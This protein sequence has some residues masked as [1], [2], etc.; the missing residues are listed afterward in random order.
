MGLFS[1]RKSRATHPKRRGPCTEAASLRFPCFS[2][3]FRTR[4]DPA[5]QRKEVPWGTRKYPVELR[6]R[7]V[8]LYRESESEAGDPPAGRAARRKLNERLS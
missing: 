6:E 4:F 3:D 5:N 7:A 8:R 1:K 2:G